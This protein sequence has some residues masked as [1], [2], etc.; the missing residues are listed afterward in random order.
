MTS[1]ALEGLRRDAA[2]EKAL[3]SGNQRR[4]DAEKDWFEAQE[5]SHEG[6]T[7]NLRR[8]G[9]V[10]RPRSELDVERGSSCRHGTPGGLGYDGLTTRR[11]GARRLTLGLWCPILTKGRADTQ[12]QVG[13]DSGGLRLEVLVW[14]PAASYF[15]CVAGRGSFGAIT[16]FFALVPSAATPHYFESIIGSAEHRVQPEQTQGYSRSPSIE[17]VSLKLLH[18]PKISSVALT[19]SEINLVALPLRWE[20]LTSL[21]LANQRAGPLLPLL[22]REAALQ[23]LSKCPRLRSCQLRLADDLLA[24]VLE[25][26]ILELPHLRALNITCVGLTIFSPGGFFSRVSLPEL[27]SLRFSCGTH[28]RHDDPFFPFLTVSPRLECLQLEQNPISTSVVLDLLSMLP[29][30][31]RRLLFALPP[32]RTRLIRPGRSIVRPSPFEDTA[33]K[34]LTPSLDNPAVSC[35]VLEE[36]AIDPVVDL[37]DH[38]LLQFTKARMAV[39]SPTLRRVA[40]QFQREKQFNIRPEIQAFSDSGLQVFTR[41]FEPSSVAVFSPWRGVADCPPSHT[42]LS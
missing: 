2:I 30:T 17:N 16:T 4:R 33:L 42:P 1:L 7:R 6:M 38:T 10:L 39:E 19:T 35:P 8:S 21:R 23:I 40:I 25:E 36:L 13:G 32:G 5:E 14:C 24:P 15:P 26:T 27:R 29:P 3:H 28:T 12:P 37:S 31:I 41:Y 11:F 9:L 18:G 34:A 20:N 22:T